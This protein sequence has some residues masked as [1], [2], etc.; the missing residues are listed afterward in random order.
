MF[1]MFEYGMLNTHQHV[2]LLFAHTLV[3]ALEII[4]TRNKNSTVVP[5]HASASSASVRKVRPK[6]KWWKPGHGHIS[7]TCILH[8]VYTVVNTA[9]WCQVSRRSKR[10][11]RYS[12][13]TFNI[14]NFTSSCML[15]AAH[16][17]NMYHHFASRTATAAIDAPALMVVIGQTHIYVYIIYILD[18]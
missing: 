3:Y 5:Q 9:P 1:Y 12:R 18:R 16:R 7:S 6:P 13:V 4:L 10:L 15:N 14:T 8:H 17:W 11:N 2:T